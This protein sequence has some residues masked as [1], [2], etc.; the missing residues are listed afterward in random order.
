LS[1]DP[2]VTS[3]TLSTGYS[4]EGGIGGETQGVYNPIC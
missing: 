3:T 2:P 1:Q 4:A